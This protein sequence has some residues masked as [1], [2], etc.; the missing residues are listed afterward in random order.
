[1]PAHAIIEP[2]TTTQSRLDA[3]LPADIPVH[4]RLWCT[5]LMVVFASFTNLVQAALF[6]QSQQPN[7]ATYTWAIISTFIALLS[8]FIL[9]WRADYPLIIFIICCAVS[10]IFPFDSLLAL[11][12]LTSL[13]ARRSSQ[14]LTIIA[15]IITACVAILCQLRDLF[16]TDDN[17]FWRMIFSQP[18]TGPSYNTPL[19]VTAS[20]TTIGIT[21]SVVAL[22][23]T[24]FSMLI[25][26]QIRQRAL[27]HN[28]TAQAHATQDHM[29]TLQHNLD[30]QRF[31]E[32]V[33]IEAHDTLA[34]SLSLLALNASALQANAHHIEQSADHID[35]SLRT[36]LASLA[37]SAQDIRK[38]AAGALDE[39]HS[40]IE[41]LHHPEQAA[42]FLA[43]TDDTALTRDSLDALLQD[44]RSAGMRINT[45]IDV[46]ELHILDDR[47]GKIAYRVVQEGLTNARRHAGQA[48]VS[49]QIDANPRQGIHVHVSNPMMGDAQA[50]Q[51]GG[52]GL[53]GMIARVEQVHG[54][55]QY[56][57]DERGI[58]HV[59]VRLPWQIAMQ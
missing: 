57:F 58:F 20:N 2:M 50:M 12:A 41:T 26:L 24:A 19:V 47:I 29:K 31:A 21:A 27:V 33:A 38:Q 48:E 36:Q 8:G 4:T 9:C 54:V 3:P 51:H 43:P 35:D 55:G 59:D 32:A 11:M 14:R 13:L 53:R 46:Q 25:G 42:E 15:S 17:S 6:G 39:A 30:L 34:H 22:I 18:G 40:I 28:A 7:T 23:M 52:N 56:G 49:V 44:A 45:W 16:H 10:V 37:R 1:M 5:I